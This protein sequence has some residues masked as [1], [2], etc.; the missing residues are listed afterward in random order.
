MNKKYI[1]RKNEEIQNIIKCNDKIVSNNFVIY[2]K[3][4][5]NGFNRFCISVSKKLGKANLRNLLKRKI[6]D[7]LMKNFFNSSYD[8][9]II[10]RSNVLNLSYNEMK[11]ELLKYLKGVK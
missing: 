10:L 7:I 9:V 5:E 8:Y 1:V 3:N 11:D 2:Y 6:K 4:N